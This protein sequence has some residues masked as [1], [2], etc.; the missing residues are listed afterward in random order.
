MEFHVSLIG[1]KD[2]IGEI[3]RQ[4]CRACCYARTASAAGAHVRQHGG[5]SCGHFN[6]YWCGAV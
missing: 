4:R 5:K 2:L 1:R 3:Y 6:L